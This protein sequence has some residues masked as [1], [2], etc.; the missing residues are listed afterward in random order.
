MMTCQSAYSIL[1]DFAGPVATV[2]AATVAAL[3]AAYFARQQWRTAQRQAETAIDQLRFNLFEKRYAIYQ[4]VKR[5]IVLTLNDPFNP[6]FGRVA[7]RHNAIID[8]AIF[9]FSPTTCQWL[10]TVRA[11][12]KALREAD[13]KSAAAGGLDLRRQGYT[14]LQT[15]LVDHSKEMT[16]RFRNEL[17]FRQLTKG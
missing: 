9:F 7:M 14:D 11:D 2:I 16:S 17:S 15:K 8:E 6:E 13:E 5:L 10:E 12:C 1:K 4:G 3:V